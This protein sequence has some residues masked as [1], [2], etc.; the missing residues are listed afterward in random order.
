MNHEVI[1]LSEVKRT[2]LGHRDLLV[3]MEKRGALLRSMKRSAPSRYRKTIE[4]IGY[5][6]R[7]G[8]VD[9]WWGGYEY[10]ID[11]GE[12]DTPLRLIQT[13][14][15]IGQKTWPGMTPARISALILALD[16]HFGWDMWRDK[17]ETGMHRTKRSRRRAARP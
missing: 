11:L 15:H 6:L 14:A 4:G 7:K 8:T 16:K 3:E 5:I 17:L 9:I 10:P 12:V 2:A 1:T 13:L